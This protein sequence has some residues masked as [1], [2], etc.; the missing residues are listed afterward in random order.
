MRTTDAKTQKLVTAGILAAAVLVM[1]LLSVPTVVGY[2]NAGDAAVLL[3]GTLL[4]GGWGC[5][6]AVT[7]SVLADLLLGYTV[8]I[9]AT[10]IVK[11]VASLLSSFLTRR[12]PERFL[13]AAL[14]IAVLPVCAGYFLYEWTLFGVGLALGEL[15]GNFLQ[16][17]AGALIAYILTRITRKMRSVRGTRQ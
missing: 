12:L 4:G 15:P 9:P 8:Y 5:A 3:T 6:C 14:L 16:G 10:L 2:L 17:L 1:T 11:A 7:G 13:P